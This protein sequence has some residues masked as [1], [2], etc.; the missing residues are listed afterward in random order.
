MS[1]RTSVADLVNGS[2]YDEL[3]KLLQDSPGKVRKLLSLLH[4]TNPTSLERVFKSFE[5]VA[6]VFDRE[7]LLDLLRRLMWML[8]EES[9]NNCP[10]AALAVAHISLVDRDAVMPHVPVLRVYADDPSSQMRE[11]VRRSISI[12][13]NASK[14]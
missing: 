12:I 8:N 14:E 5:V 1:T 6:K 7:K 2:N 3:S 4:E 11:P 13:E 10:N 9:G